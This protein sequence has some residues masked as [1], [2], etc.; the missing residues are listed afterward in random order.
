MSAIAGVW[1]F[2]GDA[3]AQA[4]CSHLLD[5]QSAY[6]PHRCDRLVRDGYAAGRRLYRLLAED[7]FDRQPLTSDD[8]R[9]V[10]VADL[11]IDNRDELISGLAI[12]S[13]A[14][15]RLSDS[16]LLLRGCL[17]W[18][19]DVLLRMIGDFAFALWDGRD[20]TLLLA[21]DTAGERPL[22]YRRG[23][24]Y[25]AFASMA[26]PLAR[27]PGERFDVDEDKLAGFVADLPPGG[28]RSFFAEV[29]ALEPGHCARVTEGEVAVRRYW[30][31]RRTPLHLGRPEDY[32]EALREQLDAAVERRLRRGSGGIGSQLSSG[33]DSSAVTTSAAVLLAGRGEPLLAFTSAPREGFAGRVVAGRIG[34][35]SA[36]AATTAALHANIDHRIVRPA[37]DSALALLG[38]SH[39]LAGQPVGH[40]CNNLWWQAINR[41]AGAA[42]VRVMLTG[43]VGNFTI[44]AGLGIDTL[45]DLVRTGAWRRWWREA[46]ALIRSRQ[47]GPLQALNASFGPWLPEGLYARLRSVRPEP[48]PFVAP[49]RRLEMRSRL[50]RAG[51]GAGPPSDSGA[52]RWTLL[53]MAD[54]GNYRKRSLA[55]WGIEERDPTNDRRLVEFCFSLPTEALL[56]QGVR[57]PALRRALAGRVPPGLLDQRL[58]G[59]QMPDW[60]E[61]ITSEEVRR[62]AAAEAAPGLAASMIDLE[63]MEAAA[64]SWPRSGWEQRSVIYR[65]RMQLLRTLAAASF[66]NMVRSGRLG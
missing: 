26:A 35:E 31:P 52:R 34:D 6:G 64:R 32:G 8:G 54:P 62:F 61:Q 18:G 44:S 9:F 38:T 50:E 1:S 37:G 66:V 27:L 36:I 40:V 63:E 24:G 53:R 48:P 29:S 4:Y 19:E 3:R 51:W 7:E 56:D 5:A 39:R 13:A 65:Y 20:R 11:R 57:R 42:G 45:G 55:E 28:R 59:Y 60:Y 22:H 12:G 46:R 23:D 43:E 10:L 21:R 41:R 30:E 17:A 2:D 49:A 25:L 14:G 33:L 16:A 15:G 58:R 47:F